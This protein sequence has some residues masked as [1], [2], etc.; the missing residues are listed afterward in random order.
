MKI[1][2]VFQ[3]VLT[4]KLIWSQKGK[5]LIVLAETQQPA[6]E[7]TTIVV[8]PS[9]YLEVGRCPI[10]TIK[11]VCVLLYCWK[12]ALLPVKSWTDRST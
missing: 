5:Y 3:V 9:F 10:K 12:P 8:S 7:A 1:F 6:D 11:S 4:N 2:D